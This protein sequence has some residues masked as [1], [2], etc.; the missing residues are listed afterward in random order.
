ME[1]GTCGW[2][3]SGMAVPRPPPLSPLNDRLLMF[4]LTSPRAPLLARLHARS[5][6]RA[7][8][9]AVTAAQRS[10]FIL[11][12]N[13]RLVESSSIKKAIES[14]YR[15]VLP[16]NT[17]PFVYLA[18]TLPRQHVDVNVHP[19]K[20]EVRPSLGGGGVEGR[21]RAIRERGRGGL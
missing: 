21:W 7:P 15:D 5:R 16:K 10:E 20:R 13:D 18:I 12:I 4:G 9:R 19:T 8:R 3:V 17:H 2:P 11:F 6:S 1:Q 14:A